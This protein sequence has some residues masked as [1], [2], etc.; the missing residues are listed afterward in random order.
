MKFLSLF[1]PK[2]IP[3][4]SLLRQYFAHKAKGVTGSTIEKHFFFYQ[5][6]EKYFTGIGSVNIQTHEIK[7]RHMEELRQWLYDDR[8]VSIGHA[9]RHIEHCQSAFDFGVLM[10]YYTHN[11]IDVIKC[12]R[13][14]A[15]IPIALTP[16]EIS[17]I[18]RANFS[19][20]SYKLIQDLCLFQCF[21]GLNYM[22]LWIYEI[23]SEEGIEW[24][25]SSMGRG[26]NG[27]TYSAEFNELARAIHNKYEGAF[28]SISVQ[29][30]NRILK[31]I[32][33][34]LNIE[35]DLSTSIGRKTYATLRYNQGMTLETISDELGNT[36]AVLNKHYI[37]R[38]KNRIKKEIDRI[39]GTPFLAV[40]LE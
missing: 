36:P 24:V 14:K 31:R 5:N 7:I 21:T 17:K 8:K 22:D 13:D 4:L 39:S 11:P 40:K 34:C 32:A 18:Q 37:Q 38:S 15:E 3:F 1:R 35:K 30:Y 20:K 6:I 29:S 10:E 19:S 2:T 28:P 25:T 12:Q 33:F 9:S 26:K 16:Q 23:T 27:K